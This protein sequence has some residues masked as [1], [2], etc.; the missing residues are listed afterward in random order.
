MTS[1]SANART[2]RKAPDRAS[3][4]SR[5]LVMI[6]L[7]L[8]ALY[9]LTPV[10]WLL[11][12][13]TKDN[14]TIISTNGFLFGKF[15]LW[16][17]LSQVFTYGNGY[18][19]RWLLNSLLYSGVGGAGA[20][21]IAMSAGYGL[22]KFRFR[23]QSLLFGGIV[24]SLL[25]PSALLTIPLYLMFSAVGIVNTVWA[26][27]IPSLLSPFGVYLGM[28]Y[29]RTAV[30]DELLEAAR[31]DGATEFRIFSTIVLRIL[32]PALVTI[33]LFT[34][35]GIWNNFFMAFVMLSDQNLFPATLG[36]YQWFSEPQHV[37]F[38]MVVT[39]SL[40]S[41]IPLVAAF[42]SLQ[43][44]WRGGLTLGSVKG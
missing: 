9:F 43:R 5:V 36:L 41:V 34:F 10:W 20:T 28:V 31:M 17:N 2:S 3:S 32:S 25:I 4:R 38:S 12:T 23:G 24:A 42:I 37:S 26:V 14:P 29:T 13:T 40:L 44:F 1:A 16:A 39:G 6:L 21:I 22:A 19:A 8:A 35:V 18:F 11:V 33:F 27:L 7:V 15:S 30:P